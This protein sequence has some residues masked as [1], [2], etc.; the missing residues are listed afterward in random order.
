MAK[1]E[2]QITKS[3]HDI[4]PAGARAMVVVEEG[5][6]EAIIDGYMFQF[7]VHE[8]SNGILKVF[9]HSYNKKARE[10]LKNY[11][12]TFEKK[13][14]NEIHGDEFNKRIDE[15]YGRSNSEG[16]MSCSWTL[17]NLDELEYK[18]FK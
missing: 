8:Y 3:L 17:H 2:K 11:G 10:I 16:G 12:A 15:I 5:N 18:E 6:V 13:T 14:L 7:T 1:T 9:L 4:I